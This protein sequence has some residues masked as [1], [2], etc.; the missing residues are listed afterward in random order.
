MAR[1]QRINVCWTQTGYELSDDEAAKLYKKEFTPAMAD[2][3]KSLGV[4]LVIL[5]FW[6]GM[7]SLDQERAGM[8]DTRRFT[9]LLHARG[10]RV[11]V[12]IHNMNLSL[13]FLQSRP[14]AYDWLAWPAPSR[15][16]AAPPPETESE[17]HP[18]YRNHPDYLRFM[19]EI[20]DMA[21]REVGADFLHFDNFVNTT[22]FSPVAIEH[23]RTYLLARY[24]ARELEDVFRLDNLDS[25]GDFTFRNEAPLSHEWIYFQGWA[26]AEC[27]RK[28]ADYARS[29]NPDVAVEL[30]ACGIYKGYRRPINLSLLLPHGDAFW[31]EHSAAG[32]DSEKRLLQSGIRSYKLARLFHQH[33]LLYVLPGLTLCQALAFNHNSLGCPFWFLYAR[34]RYASAPEAEIKPAPEIRFFHDHR[35]LFREGETLADVAMF[36]GNAVNLCGPGEAAESAY[37]FE[38]AMITHHI[39]FDI[40]FD[41]HLQHLKKYKVVALPDVRWM[42]DA[43]IQFLL[44]FVE[45]GGGLVVTDQ[46]AIQDRLGRPRDNPLRCFFRRPVSGENPRVERRGKGRVLYIRMRRP[47]VFVDGSL[48]ENDEELAQAVRRVMRA[49]SVSVDAPPEVAMEV[50]RNGR[51]LLI[52][53]LNYAVGRMSAPLR[54]RVAGNL[55]RFTKVKLLSP[56]LDGALTCQA[57]HRDGGTEIKVPAFRLYALLAL[58]K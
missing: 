27:Y 55:G 40:I 16:F 22:G 6:S 42:E 20:I 28:L 48:P 9:R 31:D 39:P 30:N 44:R 50:I 43:Q 58:E 45:N 12:Y 41:Q 38:Q 21:V 51:K 29:L 47:P 4:T 7:G 34:L 25:L 13:G 36:R 26:L 53:L 57:V 35:N 46:T 17:G 49:P 18:V 8:E 5:P 37:W 52:H 2:R 23:F 56:Y 11:G 14:D 10:L 3:L 32:W 19:F 33:A 54:I 1:T 15:P 24:T